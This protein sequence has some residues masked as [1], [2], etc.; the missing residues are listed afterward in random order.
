[1]SELEEPVP[2]KVCRELE[3]IACELRRLNRELQ[4]I[5]RSS[6]YYKVRFWGAMGACMTA[7]LGLVLVF[8]APRRVSAAAYT[9]I[10][11]YGGGR[12]WGA[13]LIAGAT[14]TLLC[15][16]RFHSILRWAL[17]VEAILYGGIA[18]SFLI[19]SIR[20]PDA[21]L[22]AAPVYA[23]VMIAHVFLSD[24]AR[25]EFLIDREERNRAFKTHS[26]TFRRL[27]RAARTPKRPNA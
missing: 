18:L 8:G 6:L 17:I 27:K 4:R 20:F 15:V 23:W 25:R 7:H 3:D 1:M 10:A 2:P 12:V 16:W 24:V 9:M 5:L 21:N 13:A 22:T 26:E 14:F 19:A 11:E